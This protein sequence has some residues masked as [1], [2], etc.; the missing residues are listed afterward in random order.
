MHL[1]YILFIEGMSTCV[2]YILMFAYIMTVSSA[3]V[4]GLGLVV[5]FLGTFPFVLFIDSD[6][7]SMCVEAH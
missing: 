6:N 2:L 1:Q 3:A 7:P 4:L 5:I